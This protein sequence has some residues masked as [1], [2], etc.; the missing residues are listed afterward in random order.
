MLATKA[1]SRSVAAQPFGK[2]KTAPPSPTA[3]NPVPKPAPP[4]L[5]AITI[6]RAPTPAPGN[7]VPESKDS[8]VSRAM[9]EA[10]ESAPPVALTGERADLARFFGP[11]ADKY[12]RVYD[13]LTAKPG[14]LSFNWPASCLS[15]VWFFYRKLY[16]VG[17]AFLI[18]PLV[19]GYLLPFGA[20]VSGGVCAWFANQA[21]IAEAKRRIR[22]ANELG[23]TDEER[24]DY[25]RRAG[26]VSLPAAI[27]A[28]FLY[29][30]M[31]ALSFLR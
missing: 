11:Y 24:N 25:L 12:L 17:A 6:A 4:S 8:D 31:A 2:R 30:G 5:A 27:G 7:E 15:F 19:M 13:Q 29:A 10:T 1:E 3:G 18:V 9:P 26:G 14:S 23:L 28:G 22:E 16:L 21:Y 20:E